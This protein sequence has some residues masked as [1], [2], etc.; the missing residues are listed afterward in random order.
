MRRVLAA[1]LCPLDHLIVGG[2]GVT[3]KIGN[4]VVGGIGVSGSPGQDKDA[5]CARAGLD[6]IRDRL[7]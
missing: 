2:G 7:K 4:E 3:I 6:K 5:A 1:L